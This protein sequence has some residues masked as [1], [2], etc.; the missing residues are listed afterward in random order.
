MRG[1]VRQEGSPA[2]RFS[3]AIKKDLRANGAPRPLRAR[4]R[5][6]MDKILL[7]SVVGAAPG[8]LFGP[9]MCAGAMEVFAPDDRRGRKAE[10]GGGTAAAAARGARLAA[11]KDGPREQ[12]GGVNTAA[13]FGTASDARSSFLEFVVL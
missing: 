1:S 6:D 13:R 12:R 2:A 8:G 11:A 3:L 5:E 9:G 7:M 4:T 10:E